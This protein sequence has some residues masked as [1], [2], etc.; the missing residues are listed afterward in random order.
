MI[1]RKR[2]EDAMKSWFATRKEANAE[3]LRRKD[4]NRFNNDLIFKW[5]HTKRKRPFFVGSR[6]E[7]LNK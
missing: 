6:L 2:K 5:T 1:K 3:L 7:W 4:Q